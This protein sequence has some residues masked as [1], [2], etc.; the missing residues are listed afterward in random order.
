MK[1]VVN[2]GEKRQLTSLRP[3]TLKD[4]FPPLKKKATEL[5]GRN[6]RGSQYA[7]NSDNHPGH[8][9]KS[10]SKNHQAEDWGRRLC[11]SPSYL[12]GDGKSWYIIVKAW[13]PTPSREA[14]DKEWAL[15]P[16]NRHQLQ[17]YGRPVLEKRWSQSWGFSYA[18]SGATN[19]ARPLS[20]STVLPTLLE[21][22]NG[23][24]AC[25]AEH[26]DDGKQEIQ[27]QQPYNGCLQNWYTPED[28][29]GLH[30]DDEKSLCKQYPIMS[31]SW[32]GTRRF[33]FRRKQPKAM[34]T[35]LGG[36]SSTTNNK[37]T[38]DVV[39]L[40]L[41]DGDLLVMGGTC[42]E[43]HKHEVPKLRKTK[44]PPT[45]NRINWTVRAFR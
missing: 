16:A 22:I 20:E 42:Q 29:I 45:T 41:E 38:N 33:L 30:A 2:A 18:Y 34:G 36:S 19:Q 28:S 44:D 21:T 5:P 17:V 14:F 39:E 11:Q 1:R 35:S 13:M 43:T 7:S 26:S 25:N 40:W 27:P 15:H 9:A 6:R 12:T 24:L 3:S 31:L 23:L 8:S 4:F 10:S 37:K 32:G